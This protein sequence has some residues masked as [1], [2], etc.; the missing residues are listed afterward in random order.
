MGVKDVPGAIDAYTRA[1]FLDPRKTV[2]YTNRAVAFNAIR[3]HSLAE[4]DCRHILLK[5]GI[6]TKPCA[7][8]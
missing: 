4:L 5:D 3:K 1:I 8:T 6:F 2:Y 7:D